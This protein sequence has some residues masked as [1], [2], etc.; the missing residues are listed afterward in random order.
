LSN[1]LAWAA[2]SRPSL[3]DDATARAALD[4]RATA[5]GYQRKQHG[6]ECGPYRLH[7]FLFGGE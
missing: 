4:R 7:W 3:R 1:H 6:Y 2:H 5:P